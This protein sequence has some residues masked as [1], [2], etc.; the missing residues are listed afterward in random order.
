MAGLKMILKFTKG[1]GLIRRLSHEGTVEKPAQSGIR[2]IALK[3]EGEAKKA[4]VVGTPQSTGKI[5]YHGG[6]L[7][8][9]MTHKFFEMGAEIGSNVPYASFVEYGTSKMKARHMEGGRKV[10]GLGML[11]YAL[12]VTKGW[13]KQ[14]GDDIAKKIAERICYGH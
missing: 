7:R 13:I 12:K 6:R 3:L 10:P 1:E 14:Q 8:S 9:S 5:G 4:T 2:R 11:G